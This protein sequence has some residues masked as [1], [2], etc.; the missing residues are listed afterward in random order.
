M[1]R[2]RI[3]GALTWLWRGLVAFAALIGLAFIGLR[4]RRKHEERARDF[5]DA[6]RDVRDAGKR[7][8]ADEVL[9]SFDEATKK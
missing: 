7:G 8:D 2:H 6:A 9:R 3:S 5:E 1:A 4:N